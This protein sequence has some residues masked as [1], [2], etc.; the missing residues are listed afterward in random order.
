MAEFNASEI[1][2]DILESGGSETDPPPYLAADAP[3]Y[4]GLEGE[5]NFWSA[6]RR[7]RD[8]VLEFANVYDR[9]K[10][11]AEM[12]A[13]APNLQDEYNALME[14]GRQIRERVQNVADTIDWVREQ[15][16]QMGSVL[17]GTNRQGL[18]IAFTLTAVIVTVTGAIAT[19]TK[20]LSDAYALNKKVQERQRL[21]E[22]GHTSDEVVAMQRAGRTPQTGGWFGGLGDA[23]R[24]FALGAAILLLAS[25]WQGR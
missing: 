12:V 20:W 21:L 4:R 1:V 9:L 7:F 16:K 11:G 14:R 25:W 6:V 10:D 17:E 5:Q 22:A 18:G 19:M 15:V 2:A 13:D 3:P 23:G 24:M 8:K